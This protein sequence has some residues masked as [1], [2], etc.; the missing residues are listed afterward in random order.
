MEKNIEDI[1]EEDIEG[2]SFALARLYRWLTSTIETRK[3]D[4]QSRIEHKQKLKEEREEAVEKYE[5]RE[6]KKAEELEVAK[7]EFETFLEGEKEK[8]EKIKEDAAAKKAAAEGGDTARDS[9][10]SKE[11]APKDEGEDEGEEEALP[12]FDEPAFMEKFDEA[13]EIIEIPPEVV[14]DIDNDYELPPEEE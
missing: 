6:T 11:D 5:E 2:Y 7:E 9:A 8:R 14:D 12:E 13:N 3:E 4:I 10:I 1:N